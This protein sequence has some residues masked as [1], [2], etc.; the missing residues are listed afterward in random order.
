M[1]PSVAQI[2]G[3]KR[4]EDIVFNIYPK[5]TR[6]QREELSQMVYLAL[7]ETSD[8][9]M[10]DLVST[11]AENFYIVRLVINNASRNGRFY[12]QTL[13]WENNREPLNARR[14]EE[15]ETP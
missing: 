8:E 7:C 10:E 12:R 2:A 6:E 4:V 14:Y 5:M 15:T 9:R 3:E 13:K 11:G 1:H